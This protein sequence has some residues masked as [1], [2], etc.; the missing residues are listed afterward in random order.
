MASKGT[1]INLVK[2]SN[3]ASNKAKANSKARG[4]CR[5]NRLASNPAVNRDKGKDKV[6]AGSQAPPPMILANRLRTGNRRCATHYVGK[7]RTCLDRDLGRILR[8]TRWIGRVDPWKTQKTRCA[9]M[10]SPVR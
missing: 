6:P 4:R 2:V 7:N 1:K 5:D 3:K 10:T 8:A 9:T